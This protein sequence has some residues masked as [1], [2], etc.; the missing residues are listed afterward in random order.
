M[1]PVNAFKSFPVAASNN[2][3][4]ESSVA[5]K[6]VVAS[7]DGTTEVTGSAKGVNVQLE[8]EEQKR[9]S[10]IVCTELAFAEV[11]RTDVAVDGSGD[12][13]RCVDVEGLYSIPGFFKYLDRGTGLGSRNARALRDGAG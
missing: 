11:V 7:I 12:D 3:T 8:K 10:D 6:S 2:L 4:C 9:T 1:C 5:T 13:A